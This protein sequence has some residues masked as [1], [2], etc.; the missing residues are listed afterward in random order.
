ME[1]IVL[2]AGK[3]TR[4]RGLCNAR[5]KPML[6][7][8]NRPILD[9]TVDHLAHAGIER[10]FVVIGHLADQIE[11]HF[12]LAAPPVPV[13]FIVQEQANGTGSAA[14]L[15]R[16]RMKEEPFFLA[17]GDIF[18]SGANYESMATR[19]RDASPDMLLATRYVED[20]YRGAAVYVNTEGFVERIVE[21]PPE[22]TSSTHF[23]NAGLFCF[24][25]RIWDLL[26]R[27]EPSPRGEYELTDAVAATLAE[28]GRVLAHELQG[29]W[30]NLTGPEELLLAN[31]HRLDETSSSSGNAAAIPDTCRIGPHTSIGSA[32]ALGDGACVEDAIVMDGASIGRDAV[33]RH[34]VIGAGARVPDGARLEGT[35]DEAVVLLDGREA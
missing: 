18:V 11:E 9:V 8:A 25:P 4:M 34:A 26:E 17:F 10:V 5:P 32:C 13:E 30:L 27:I 2:A 28:D 14:L 24:S 19:F 31:E 3:G 33:V 22:G 21:K 35:A 23:D 1:A 7:V 16:G 12:R 29:Y 15:G 6:P 20:P